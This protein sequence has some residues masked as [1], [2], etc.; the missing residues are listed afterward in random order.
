MQDDSSYP[1][2]EETGLITARIDDEDMEM[3]DNPYYNL[4][5]FRY[6]LLHR[7]LTLFSKWWNERGRYLTRPLLF[8]ITTDL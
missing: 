1:F 4:Y 6:V 3:E 8:N 5:A 7:D 2:D